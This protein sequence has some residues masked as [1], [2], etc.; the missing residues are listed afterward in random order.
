MS[1]PAELQE[2]I[3]RLRE[4][5]RWALLEG[6]KGFYTAVQ[7][8]GIW[9]HCKFCRAVA[10]DPKKLRHADDCKYFHVKQMVKGEAA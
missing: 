7:G 5:L 2:E 9:Y 4:A 10:N 1:T 3:R 6:Q 8:D